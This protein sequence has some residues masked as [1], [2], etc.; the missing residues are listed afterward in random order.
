MKP[1]LNMKVLAG[2]TGAF[3]LAS[4]APLAFG[5]I[6]IS[7]QETSPSGPAVL[8]ATGTDAQGNAGIT[9]GASAPGVTISFLSAS[10]NSPGTSS[11]SQQF[12][13]TLQISTTAPVTL[14]VWFAAQDFTSPTTPP[15]LNYTSSL[16]VT[17]TT[18]TG[19]VGLES[20]IDGANGLAPPTGVFCASPEATITNPDLNYSGSTITG[21]TIPDRIIIPVSSLTTTP[22]SLSQMLTLTLGAN[23]NLNVIT[24]QILTPVPEPASLALLGSGLLGLALFLRRKTQAKRG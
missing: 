20:C 9:C 11:L 22:F 8:C 21:T 5:D 3:M 15:P 24:S 7:Y 14:D 12:G 1:I 10:S 18:G 13:S 19:T 4:F 23:S 6:Q 2:A 17:A 16:A